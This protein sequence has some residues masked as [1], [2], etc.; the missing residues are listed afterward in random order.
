MTAGHA[1]ALAL[2][3]TGVAFVLLSALALVRLRGTPMRL[4]AL[5]PATCAGLPLIAAAVAVDQGPGRAAA[6][7]LFIGLLFA[8]G[9][10][11]TTIAVGR[12]VRQSENGEDG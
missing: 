7:T 3:W 4:H 2:L 12:A 5:A 11:V 8:V 6:R 1:T 10:T 9:G